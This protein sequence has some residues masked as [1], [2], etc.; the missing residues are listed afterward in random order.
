MPNGDNTQKSSPY[1]PPEQ[2]PSRPAS[3]KSIPTQPVVSQNEV[4]KLLP[5]KPTI[6][7]ESSIR[8][9]LAQQQTTPYQNGTHRLPSIQLK[10]NIPYTSNIFL[11]I[12][13]IK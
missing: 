8:S 5:T 6:S 3:Q 1:K 7:R 11:I 9:S 10:T 13:E 12:D 4:P 2:T